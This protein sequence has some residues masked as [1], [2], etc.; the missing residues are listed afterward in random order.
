M[1]AI[2]NRFGTS[3]SIVSGLLHP[4]GSFTSTYE[5]SID[6]RR[7]GTSLPAYFRAGGLRVKVWGD[8]LTV[9]GNKISD[10]QLGALKLII[11]QSHFGRL[12]VCLKKNYK[13]VESFKK[14]NQRHLLKL[15]E[16]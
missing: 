15:L 5:H 4:D 16:N 11:R 13:G 12:G 14:I 10:K 2:K 6:C 7:A 9:E 1:T 3:N 8:E